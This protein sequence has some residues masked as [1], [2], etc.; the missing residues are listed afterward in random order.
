MKVFDSRNTHY[1]NEQGT[2]YR[3]KATDRTEVTVAQINL[4]TD[5][6]TNDMPPHIRCVG[7]EGITTTN[8]WAVWK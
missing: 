2:V 6:Q 5:T 8:I 4:Q 3:S 7:R 1:Q